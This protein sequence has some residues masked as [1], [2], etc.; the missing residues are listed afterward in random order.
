MLL[1]TY[2]WC[3]LGIAKATI[4]PGLIATLDCEIDNHALI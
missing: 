3:V 2:K 1:L 4:I